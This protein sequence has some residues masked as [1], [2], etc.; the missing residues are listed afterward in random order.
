[1]I[2]KDWTVSEL[3]SH[4][5]NTNQVFAQYKINTGC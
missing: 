2:E 4:F 3:V 5:L 1:M